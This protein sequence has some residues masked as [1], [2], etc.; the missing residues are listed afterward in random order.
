M[1]KECMG[2]ASNAGS[3]QRRSDYH[4]AMDGGRM[5]P[6]VSRSPWR[7]RRRLLLMVAH[8]SAIDPGIVHWSGQGS[9]PR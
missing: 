7:R 5:E 9:A 2:K 3:L 8:A 4:H 1:R 6:R